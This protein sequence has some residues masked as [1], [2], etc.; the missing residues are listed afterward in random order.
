[1]SNPRRRPGQIIAKLRQPAAELGRGLRVPDVCRKLGVTE[2]TYYR[3]RKAPGGLRTDPAKRLKAPG[4]ENARLKKPV[5]EAEL[6]EA[7][8]RGAAAGNG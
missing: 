4:R 3:W 2:P 7:I 5:A 8:L 1:V 6:D